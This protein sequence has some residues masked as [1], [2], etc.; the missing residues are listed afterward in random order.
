MEPFLL[1]VSACLAL[2]LASI[3]AVR[4]SVPPAHGSGIHAPPAWAVPTDTFRIGTYNI[5]RAKGVDG[6]RDLRRTASVLDGTDVVGVQEAGGSLLL[7][8]EDQ[9][10]Q[11]G[12]MRDM[13]WLFM[14][15]QTRWFREDRGNGL[16]SRFPVDSWYREPLVDT[17]R[18]KRSLTTCAVTIGDRTVMV[19]V[20]HLSKRRDQSLHIRTALDRFRQYET[21]VLMGDFNATRDNALLRNAIDEGAA[22]DAIADALGDGDP[23][24]RVDWIL[25]RG[26]DVK[27]GGM[28]SV[29]VSDHPYF[30]VELGFT[31][32]QSSAG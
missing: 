17:T 26:L 30:W 25:T 20:A 19:L 8:G 12:R 24:N 11:L 1:V 4:R 16:L 10:A 27:R 22:F 18:R 23:E 29:G 28:Q 5:H 32:E 7:G 31:S 6:T 9:V 2:A 3:A 15:T 13:G 21:A 14:P